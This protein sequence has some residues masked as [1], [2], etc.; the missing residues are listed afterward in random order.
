MVLSIVLAATA[1]AAG[2]ATA[3]LSDPRATWISRLPAGACIGLA[4]CGLVGF[5]LASW[6]GLH[7]GTVWGTAIVLAG[8]CGVLLVPATPRL[9]LAPVADRWRRGPAWAAG[10]AVYAAGL[11]L[12]WRIAD[13]SM[14]VADGAIFTGVS[15]NIGDLPFHL[16]VMSRFVRGANFPPEHPSFAGAG[17]TYPF[18]TDFIGSL[19]VTAGL[20]TRTVMV[21]STFL[22]SVAL[23]ALL[24]RWTLA[25]TGSRGAAFLAPL[26][27]LMSGGLGWWRFVVESAQ[28]G[29]GPWTLLAN[30]PHD[31]T[32]TSDNEY[33]WGN[34]V[35]SLLVTQRGLLL[36]LPLAIVVFHAWWR[37]DDEPVDQPRESQRVMAGAGIV[38]GLLPLVHAHGFAVVL[39]TAAV[40]ALGSRRWR[41]WMPFFVPALAVGLPQVWWVTRASGIRGDTFL[42]WAPGWDR[43]DQNV[44]LFW[45][46]NTGLFLPLLVAALFWRANPPVVSRRLLLFYLPFTLWFIVPNLVR[47]APW[48][49]DNI[50]VLIFWFIASVPLVAALLAR[51]SQGA[52][53]RRALGAALLLSL[54]TAGALDLWRVASGGFEN[55]VFDR[56]GIE[57]AELLARTSPPSALVL[58]APVHNHAVVLAGRRSLMGYPGHVWS[59]GLDAGPRSADIRRMYA[60]GPTAAEL[61][62]RYGIDYVVVGPQERIHM[63][64]DDRFFERLPL[65]G[66]TAGYRLYRTNHG[67][68]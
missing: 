62:E 41:M 33:R 34:L 63:T 58:H 52:W 21:W 22:L 11:A 36:G 20:P 15:H 47:L 8:T 46:K 10:A 24:F 7:A 32:I 3:R 60:G 16:A 30:L 42:A 57:L 19:F 39:A 26:L 44:L 31:Y 51:V 40:L 48:I 23:A 35:T 68:D 67:R 2:V 37:A 1:L 53:W 9:H 5:I 6:S 55:R 54:T 43:G 12:L 28:A 61:L 45:L 66:E 65:V 27:A 64:I 25:L 29:S 17:F 50:K 14:Y 18:L 56:G 4:L 38:A 59:H 13:R 49:W